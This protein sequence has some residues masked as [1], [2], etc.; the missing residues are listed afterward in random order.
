LI[1][2]ARVETAAATIDPIVL[3]GWCGTNFFQGSSGRPLLT[4]RCLIALHLPSLR[5]RVQSMQ[6]RAAVVDIGIVP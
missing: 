3:N 2:E 4:C 6:V 5:F 1:Q